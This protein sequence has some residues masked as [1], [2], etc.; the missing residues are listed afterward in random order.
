MNVRL[1]L[2]A[3]L[4]SAPGAALAE[5]E[6][7]NSTDDVASVA[8]GYKGPQGWTSEG[9]WNVDP[10]ACTVAIRGDLPL[11]HYYYRVISPTWT[12]DHESYMFCTSRSVFTIVGDTNCAARGYDR[13]GFNEIAMEGRRAFTIEIGGRS[14]EQDELP[15]LFNDLLDTSP[16]VET[17]PP[18]THGDYMTLQ[19]IFSHCDTFDANKVCFFTTQGWVIGVDGNGPTHEAIIADLEARPVNTP[20]MFS[21][22]VFEQY[23]GRALMAL[24]DYMVTAP[25]EF[26]SDRAAMQGDW[27]GIEDPSLGVV[28][29]GS[30]FTQIYPDGAREVGMMHFGNGCLG[31]QGDGVSVR[32]TPDDP[33]DSD[34]CFFLSYVDGQEMDLLYVDT[35]GGGRAPISLS[36]RKRR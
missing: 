25:D 21:G 18:G 5:L 23:G 19:G 3:M 11:S 14:Q 24:T 10:G 30:F 13:E 17:D 28:V 34:Q 8:I 31:S 33:A 1:I 22:D 6:F 16:Q 29:H 35:T 2:F 4:A 12:F 36:Y 9:W 20:M 32:L 27:V 26:A 7:C 15:A